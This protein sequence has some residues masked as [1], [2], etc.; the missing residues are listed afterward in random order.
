M[1]REAT[2]KRL[3]VLLIHVETL[4]NVLNRDLVLAFK[5]NHQD[6]DLLLPLDCLVHYQVQHHSRILATGEADID[7]RE[8]VE[9]PCYPFPG[10]RQNVFAYPMFRHSCTPV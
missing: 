7:F 6:T 9:R 1:N 2:P 5:V 10:R 3:D 4:L 8:S